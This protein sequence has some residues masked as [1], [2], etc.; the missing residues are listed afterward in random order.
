MKNTGRNR[1]ARAP[2]ADRRASR[3]P[4]PLPRMD[5][6]NTAILRQMAAVR[7]DTRSKSE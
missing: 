7:K 6:T 3:D 2:A 5:E 4:E 1:K